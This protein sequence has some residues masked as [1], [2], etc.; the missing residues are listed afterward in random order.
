VLLFSSEGDLISGTNK[1]LTFE[2][3]NSISG[4]G[5][6]VISEWENHISGAMNFG[7]TLSGETPS[8]DEGL[9]VVE[10]HSGGFQLPVS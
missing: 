8:V 7:W 3:E 4:V 10:S 1:L 5:F 9:R 2:W 6:I